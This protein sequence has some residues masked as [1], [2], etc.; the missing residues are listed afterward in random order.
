MPSDSLT[1]CL[2]V[3]L[4]VSPQGGTKQQ[5]VMGVGFW[6]VT[7]VSLMRERNTEKPRVTFPFLRYLVSLIITSAPGDLKATST[8][9][10]VLTSAVCTLQ[11]FLTLLINFPVKACSPSL[12]FVVYPPCARIHR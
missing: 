6:E 8:A 5:T 10:V 9:S 3:F 1:F 4:K 12:S 11:P 7:L 2:N